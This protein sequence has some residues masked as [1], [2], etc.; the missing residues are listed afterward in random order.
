MTPEA[1]VQ[2]ETVWIVRDLTDNSTLVDIVWEARLGAGATSTLLRLDRV[3]QGSPP[4]AMLS[5]NWTFWTEEYE[6]RRDGERCL[7]ARHEHFCKN[8][9]ASANVA[10]PINYQTV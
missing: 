5:E 2:L 9:R 1:A 3:I 4:N 7:R 6:A 10:I 8:H